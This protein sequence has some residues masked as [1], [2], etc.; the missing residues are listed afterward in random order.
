MIRRMIFIL[1]VDS[2]ESD[3]DCLK[4]PR[5]NITHPDNKV[6]GANMGS[7]WGRQMHSNAK[8]IVNKIAMKDIRSCI[9]N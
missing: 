3:C 8:L 5:N 9:Q 7:I 4:G 6:H 1:G 2:G